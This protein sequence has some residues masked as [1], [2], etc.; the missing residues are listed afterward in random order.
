[1][2]V[3]N[4][5]SFFQVDPIK[6]LRTLIEEKFA[7]LE[8]RITSVENKISS[9]YDDIRNSISAVKKSAIQAIKLGETNSSLI[10][11]NTEMITSHTF[12]IDSLN[13]R[14]VDLENHLKIFQDDLD[15]TRNQSL[16]KTL[17]FRNIKQDSLR[18]SWD[19]TKR[20]LANEIHRVIPHRSPEEILSKIERAHRPKENQSPVSQHNKV[21]PIIAKFTD[22]TFT[23]EIKTSF[24]KVA[25]NSRHNHIVY[26]SQMSSPAVTNRW[27]EAM[28]VRKQ[29]RNE[30]KQ[31]QAYVKF[32]AI[33]MVKKPVE[34]T[35]SVHSEY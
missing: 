31:T 5:G 2:P 22:W 26:V 7:N 20:I 1:M 4:L 34:T 15:D 29:L 9:Q 24:I 6:E 30:D 12:D 14:I 11:E 19:T 33:L 28:K 21:P 23:E 17:I 27:N 25:K 10:S 32:P 13:K 8:Q 18:E 16:R 3:E 35:Y